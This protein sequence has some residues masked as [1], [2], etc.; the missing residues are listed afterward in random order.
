MNIFCGV[1]MIEVK[2]IKDSIDRYGKGFVEKIFTPEEINYCESR[3]NQKFQ[4]YAARFAAKEAVSKALGTGISNGVTLKS[5]EVLASGTAGKPNI[6]FHGGAKELFV[7]MGGISADI[8][9]THT[10]DYATA[11]AVLLCK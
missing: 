1:D 6:V 8:S 11:F 10:K 7:K 9:L 4:S 3:K 2:R 5:I